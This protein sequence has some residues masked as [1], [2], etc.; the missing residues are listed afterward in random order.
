MT[1]TDPFAEA[2][3]VGEGNVTFKCEV[4][5]HYRCFFVIDFT[6]VRQLEYAAMYLVLNSDFGTLA[7]GEDVADEDFFKELYTLGQTVEGFVFKVVV[8]T[9]R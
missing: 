3:V 1:L 5:T 2:D 4:K 9:E 7:E 6:R 8:L